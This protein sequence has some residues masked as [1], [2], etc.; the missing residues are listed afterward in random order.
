[1]T[2]S[3]TIPHPLELLAP[4]RDRATAMAALACGADAVY[5][6]APSHGARA[7]AACSIADIEA[8]A[9]EAHRFRARVYVALNTLIYDSELEEV[10]KMIWSLYRAGADALIIQD[11][12]ITAMK[13]PPIALHAS[14]QTDIRSVARA[15]EM[16]A[17]GMTRI[18]VAREMSIAETAEIH[19]ELPDMEIEAFVHGALCVSYSGD[20]RASLAATGRSANRGECAQMCRHAYSLRDSRGDILAGPA[21]LLSL[22][23]LNRSSRLAEMAAAGVTS[24]KIEGRLK[25]EAYVRETVAYYSRLLDNLVEGSGGRYRRA[26]AGRVSLDFN[27]D[28]ALVFNRGFT[29][30]FTTGVPPKGMP[31]K[32]ASLE[33]PGASGREIGSVMS[34]LPKGGLKLRLND[35]I[36]LSAGD[37]L[38]YTDASGAVA[39]FRVNR[40]EG[41]SVIFLPPGVKAPPR[42]TVLRRTYDAARARA[43]SRDDIARRRLLLDITLRHTASGRIV[44]EARDLSRGREVSVVT[45][46]AFTDRASSPQDGRRRQPFEKIGGDGYILNKFTDAVDNG[47]FVP[48]SALT[49][50]RR[51][52]ITALDRVAAATYAYPAPGHRDTAAHIGGAN[53]S[54]RLARQVSP[55]GYEAAETR[56]PSGRGLEGERVMT[57]RYC[58]RR[59]YG[60]CLATAAGRQWHGPLTISDEAGNTFGLTF[61]CAGCL[62]HL[63]WLGRRKS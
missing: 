35:G 37:G 12:G 4:A 49:A 51:N 25:D 61:D 45:D 56:H 38:S 30:Y 3:P 43:L 20:C 52:L 13:L 63:E 48:S 41:S 54:N 22:R 14:T 33:S 7:A 46:D 58:L 19:R 31:L 1:M 16:A 42:G 34:T 10:E 15:R 26:S 44:A 5:I 23:D 8:V 53:I 18:V 28:P 21:H 36:T 55:G 17:L 27:P 6:G 59:E 47:L 11:I 57:T 2:A 62:M 24:F 29:Q 39:G 40:V 50:L 32:M 60:R 9:R